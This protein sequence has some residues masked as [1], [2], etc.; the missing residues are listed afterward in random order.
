MTIAD[1]A[2]TEPIGASPKASIAEVASLMSEHH[3]GSVLVEKENR[4]VGIVTDRD[5]T[6]EITAEGRDPD[7]VTVDEIMTEDPVTMPHDAGVLEVLDTMA[8]HSVRRIPIVDGEEVYG[9]VTLDDFDRLLS[10]EHQR[11]AAV[12]EAESPPY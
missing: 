4:P 1:L 7:G 2:R 12:I 3:V 9:I 10:D 6:V 8:E 5:I 11:I